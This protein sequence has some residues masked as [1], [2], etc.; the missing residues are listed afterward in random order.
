V[1]ILSLVIGY[2]HIHFI[3][4]NKSGKVIDIYDEILVCFYNISRF[5]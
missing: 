2:I 4:N 3:G 5:N 1:Y